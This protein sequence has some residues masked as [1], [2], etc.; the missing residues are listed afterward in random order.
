VTEK[1]MAIRLPK[2][3]LDVYFRTPA[4]KDAFVR[5]LKRTRERLTPPR[6]KLLS[7]HDLMLR[8]L[9]AVGMQT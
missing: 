6:E 2:H 8:M 4:D 3:S 5:R 1:K 9:D 7:Y